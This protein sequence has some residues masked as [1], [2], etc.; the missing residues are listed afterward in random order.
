MWNQSSC[1]TKR[2]HGRRRKCLNYVTPFEAL[3]G[4][5]ADGM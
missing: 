2:L 5:I 3:G 1:D 4:A